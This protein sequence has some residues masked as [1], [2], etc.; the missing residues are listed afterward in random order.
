MSARRKK[1]LKKQQAEARTHDRPV[2]QATF[3][4]EA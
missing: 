1:A 3:S 2:E 4:V